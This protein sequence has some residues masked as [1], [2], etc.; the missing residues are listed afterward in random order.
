MNILCMFVYLL[1]SFRCLSVFRNSWRR[2]DTGFHSAFRDQT[3][4]YLSIV[5]KGR[6]NTR[7]LRDIPIRESLSK[8]NLGVYDWRA[9]DMKFT[10]TCRET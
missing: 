9:L 6:A 2:K 8:K 5:T 7:Y 4:T 3:R 10:C 1:V